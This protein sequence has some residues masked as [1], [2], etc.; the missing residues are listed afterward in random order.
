MRIKSTPA[1]LEGREVQYTKMGPKL[2][3]VLQVRSGAGGAGGKKGRA[4]A[5]LVKE[6]VVSSDD[7]E[8]TGDSQEMD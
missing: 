4:T 7:E 2:V 3:E 8:E 6:E 5:R 1:V